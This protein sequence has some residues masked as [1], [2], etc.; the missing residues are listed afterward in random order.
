MHLFWISLGMVVGGTMGLNP[1]PPGSLDAICNGLTAA[2]E[3]A[4]HA[5]AI[6]SQSAP[7]PEIEALRSE[8]LTALSDA[9]VNFRLSLEQGE[10]YARAGA[11]VANNV[12]YPLE[13]FI[14]GKLETK[15]LPDIARS[16]DKPI[17]QLLENAKEMHGRFGGIQ[18]ELEKVQMKTQIHGQSVDR[19]I[20]EAQDAID[21]SRS[22][23]E[24]SNVFAGVLGVVAFA[25]PPAALLAGG[26]ALNA[27]AHHENVVAGLTA[28]QPWHVFADNLRTMRDV[29]GRAQGVT[30]EQ[31]RFWSQMRDQVEQLKDSSANWLE[32]LSSEWMATKLLTEWKGVAQQYS[33]C[34]HTTS[35]AHR[36]LDAHMTA[37]VHAPVNLG[38][39]SGFEVPTALVFTLLGYSD[40]TEGV[41]GGNGS[42]RETVGGN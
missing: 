17:A 42:G 8:L 35:D 29:V 12:I 27:D 19:A 1:P 13:Q 21:E 24:L 22:A 32:D 41:N 40:A 28:I 16:L 15:H 9:G 26:L 23:R 25:F 34:A 20:A 2:T 6:R 38:V 39:G 7:N 33:Q 5:V 3:I 30:G 14:A 18:T 37:K 31:I 11:K 10:V 4:S 36:F